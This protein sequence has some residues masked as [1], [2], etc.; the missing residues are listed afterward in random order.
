[1]RAIHLEKT[2]A[3][4]VLQLRDTPAPGCGD[5]EVLLD[6]ACCGCNWADTM[7]RSGCYPHPM[8]YPMII[9]FEVSGTV[10][11]VGSGVTKF[12]AGDRVCAI[13]TNGGGYAEQVAVAEE[14]VM[15]IP[16]ELSF[17]LA[18]AF[19]I[20]GLTVYHMLHTVYRVKP[21]DKVLCHAIGGGVGL[22][23]T[24]MAV[25]AGAG[26]IGTVGT[27]GKEELPLAYGAG[28]V[29]NYKQEDF[30]EAALEF[31]GG[32]GVDLAIDSLG[33]ATLDRTYD[34][35][36]YLGHVIN[37]GEAEGDPFNNIRER[38]MPKSISFTRFHLQHVIPGSPLWEQGRK[39]VVE[40]LLDGWLKVNIVEKFP[41]AQAAEM[42]RRL[43][44]RQ[45]AGKLLLAVNE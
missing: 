6:I 12:K 44:S 7:V 25:H 29:V 20:Q 18:A 17:E 19:P 9:G 23:A 38:T 42:H 1:M 30:V 33:A 28:R 10:A 32:A 13:L 31:S 26:V 22:Y 2:G 21:G 24:Q 39:Y 45:V 16:D 34:A 27:A 15:P 41:L 5:N 37:I 3:P 4:D 11:A 40:A 36:R 14:D 35:M 43:E 8:N